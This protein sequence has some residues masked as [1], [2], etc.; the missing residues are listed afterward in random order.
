MNI[1]YFEYKR[2]VYATIFTFKKHFLT[3]NLNFDIVPTLNDV[4][5]AMYFVDRPTPR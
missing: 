2:M 3:Q 5:I 1:G 4:K